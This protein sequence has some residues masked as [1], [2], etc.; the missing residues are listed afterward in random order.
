MAQHKCRECLNGDHEEAEAAVAL[1]SFPNDAHPNLRTKSW[2]CREHLT[3][4]R[5]DYGDDLRIL[6]DCAR[7]KANAILARILREGIPND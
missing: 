6:R 3:A 7:E 5:D 2:V 4:M 1:V